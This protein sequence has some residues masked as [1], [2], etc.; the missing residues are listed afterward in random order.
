[1]RGESTTPSTRG[2]GDLGRVLCQ[3][4]AGLFVAGA[5][6]VAWFALFAG[7]VPA[8]AIA[9]VVAGAL[10][11]GAVALWWGSGARG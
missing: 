8:P 7:T 9:E 5:A 6:L 10:A 11:A 2:P 4:P 3:A 1:M